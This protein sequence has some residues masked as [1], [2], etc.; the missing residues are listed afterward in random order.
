M[1][2]SDE[3]LTALVNKIRNDPNYFT[4]FDSIPQRCTF[5]A[6]DDTQFDAVA[7]DSQSDHVLHFSILGRIVRKTTYLRPEGPFK[8]TGANPPK[9]EEQE[10]FLKTRLKA[11]L[12]PLRD[13]LDTETAKEDWAKYRATLE[14]IIEATT[15]FSADTKIW[16]PYRTKK[17]VF[18]LNHK[19]I[20][21][22]DDEGFSRGEKATILRGGGSLGSSDGGVEPSGELNEDPI[23]E[24]EGI[25][26]V[27]LGVE[28]DVNKLTQIRNWPC[29]PDWHRVADR[30]DH[31]HYINLL[32]AFD[33]DFEFILPQQYELK[34]LG[35]VVHAKF[36]ISR[37]DIQG[38]YVF[39]LDIVELQVLKPPPAG[40]ATRKKRALVDLVLHKKRMKQRLL[41]LSASFSSVGHL[42][43]K[44]IWWLFV[45]SDHDN[46]VGEY[47]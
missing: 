43:L 26:D 2:L 18:T 16:S 41:R 30:F 32:P 13:V 34:L 5:K 21:R 46:V 15:E 4:K 44:T 14:K 24:P 6:I 33:R 45:D 47:T 42:Q 40:V 10:K 25:A 3:E 12:A 22:R 29:D 23:D 38:D 7:V 31:S 35:A 37:F 19:L 9:R 1:P 28:S 27:V 8:P 17:N 20:S 11:S 39:C 36:S